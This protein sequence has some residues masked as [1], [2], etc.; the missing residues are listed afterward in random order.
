MTARGGQRWLG[1]RVLLAIPVV[2]GVTTLTFILIHVAPGDPI[3]ALAGDG[4]TPAYYAEMR[5]RYGLDRPLLSQFLTYSGLVFS[6]DLGYSFMFQAPVVRVLADHLPSSLVLAI[7]ATLLAV[8][9]GTGLGIVCAIRPESWLDRLVS[10][11]TPVL[12]AAPV[13]WTGQVFVL[14]FALRLGWFPVGGMTSVRETLT[15]WSLIL[16]VLRHLTLPALVLALPFAAVVTSITRASVLEV[17][18]EP[19]VRAAAARGASRSAIV[20]GH[21]APNA[22]LPVT[23]LIGQHAAGLVG[24]AA[25]TESLFGWPGI[26]YLVLHASLHRDYP[27]V[28]GSFILISAGVVLVNVITD[29]VCAW[30]DPRVQLASRV[31]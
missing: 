18:T 27:L 20:V 22:A 16:D 9:I 11:I 17:L 28:T 4:G 25:L 12:Y 23:A 1:R 30:L 6:G 13:F 26:G 8:I 15:G 10:L 29:A 21:A 19:Y 5:A 31:D 2:I 24:G 3:Y 7:A 14:V